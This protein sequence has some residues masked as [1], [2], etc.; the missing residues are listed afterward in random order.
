MKELIYKVFQAYDMIVKEIE[1]RREHHA[2]GRW[3]DSLRLTNPKVRKAVS[4]LSRLSGRKVSY[5]SP[6]G[7]K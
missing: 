7:G 6:P 3:R 2:R 1:D 5:D 4:I